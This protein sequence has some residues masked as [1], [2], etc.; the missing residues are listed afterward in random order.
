LKAEHEAIKA[1]IE[2]REDNFQKAVAL[3]KQ[4]IDEGHYATEVC[5]K[6]CDYQEIVCY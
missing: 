2:A 3:C 1:E 4:M 6:N 5:L